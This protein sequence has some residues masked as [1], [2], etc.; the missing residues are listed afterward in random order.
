M[1]NAC[2][3]VLIVDDEPD[4]CWALQ[5]LLAAKGFDS[6]AVQSG[7]A[8]LVALETTTGFEIALLDVKLMDIDGLELARRI[9]SAAPSIRIIMISGYYY[10][11][12]VDIQRAVEEGLV[13]G[14]IA[15]PF[16][17]EDVIRMVRTSVTD[18]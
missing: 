1:E 3:A 9:K 6:R 13:E 4:M 10:K 8:A 2:H 16:L 18:G 15:K 17:H 11:D 12:D 5:N 14:F 7:K